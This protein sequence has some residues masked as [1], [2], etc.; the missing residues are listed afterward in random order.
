MR[1]PIPNRSDL[2]LRMGVFR[3]VSHVHV[4]EVWDEQITY[5]LWAE[6][7]QQERHGL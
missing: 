6:A 3:Q 1:V 4:L 5:P 7:M 2:A